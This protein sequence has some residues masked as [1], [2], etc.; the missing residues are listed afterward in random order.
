MWKCWENLQILSNQLTCSLCQLVDNIRDVHKIYMIINTEGDFIAPWHLAPKELVKEQGAREQWIY[1]TSTQ[2]SYLKT[3]QEHHILLLM[4]CLFF[5]FDWEK[6][7]GFSSIKQTRKMRF[8]FMNLGAQMQNIYV[9]DRCAWWVLLHT[10][11]LF[12]D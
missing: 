10:G 6:H 11:T 9:V 7:I 1:L 5:Y 4:P 3:P 2:F 12:C 8:D